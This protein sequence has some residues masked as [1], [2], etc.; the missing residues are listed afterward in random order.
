M[1]K[2]DVAKAKKDEDVKNVIEQI[3]KGRKDNKSNRERLVINCC[4]DC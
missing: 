3:L 2:I 1:K 4:C